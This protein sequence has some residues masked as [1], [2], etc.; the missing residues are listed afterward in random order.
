MWH[1]V[2]FEERLAQALASQ[3][4]LGLPRYVMASESALPWGLILL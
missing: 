4:D 3:E 1:A 2:P